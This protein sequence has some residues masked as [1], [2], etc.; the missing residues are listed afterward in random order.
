[1]FRALAAGPAFVHSPRAEMDEVA[2]APDIWLAWRD[3]LP[4]AAQD[5]R[6]AVQLA[7]E[8]NSRG[9]H[10][11]A[12]AVAEKALRQLTLVS[13]PGEAV[14]LRQQMA[15]A[16]ARSGSTEE[17]IEVLR[18]SA[19]AVP[20]DAE[21]LGLLGRL[22][23][24]L[25]D[26]AAT[27][28][29]VAQHRQRALEFYARGFAIDRSPYCGINAAVLSALTGDLPR[30]RKMARQL[31]ALPSQQDRLWT[32][33]TTAL[34]HLICGEKEEAREAL[35]LADR[36]HGLRRSDLAVVRREVRRVALA[37][38]E[39]AGA[40]DKCFRP[41]AVAV[42]HGG[43]SRLGEGEEVRLM[44][45]LE[46]RHVV[47]AWSAAASGQEAEFLERAAAWGLETCAVLPESAPREHCRKAVERASFVD[48]VAEAATKDAAAEDLARRIAT[49]RALARADS[50][51]V[52]LLA[53]AADSPPEFWSGLSGE[54]FLL[55]TDSG[56]GA[57][58]AGGGER[59]RAVLCV[60]AV[61]GAAECP[62]GAPDLSAIWAN[63]AA[64]CGAANGRGGPYFFAWPTMAE[65]GGA[66]LDLQRR[67]QVGGARPGWSF[68][69]HACAEEPAEGRLGEWASRMYPGRVHATG[70]FGELAALERQDQFD[71]CYVGTI[72][73]QAE[74][75]GVR[76]YHLRQPRT[77]IPARG[78]T[79]ER[80]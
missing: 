36:V 47:C 63:H 56:G 17:A 21:S 23:K 15:L 30:A 19:V 43:G 7:R 45:W 57:G 4:V 78:R 26:R 11:L 49:A 55:R 71:L 80:A 22:H 35:Q 74:P 51:D 59:M 14:P 44:R 5:P 1:M 33:A 18:D 6:V 27:A 61:P 65:A 12:L 50:W 20:E 62:E 34:V 66:A 52:P 8:A 42:F 48:F 3:Q 79:A 70:R 68:V 9:E 67:L 58:A 41:V 13:D 46:D 39:E 69:L 2:D 76:F 32:V 54:S 72:D 75:L 73:C 29:G 60:R 53:V 10:M 16:L 31:A 24:D 28:G 38:D 37:L 25:A 64:R 40:Y 77:G